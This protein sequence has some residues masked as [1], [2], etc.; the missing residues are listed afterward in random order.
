MPLRLINSID[1]DQNKITVNYSFSGGRKNT[2]TKMNHHY[3]LWGDPQINSAKASFGMNLLRMLI[4]S[5]LLSWRMISMRSRAI[6]FTTEFSLWRR[7]TDF[8][9]K[10]WPWSDQQMIRKRR[11]T[12]TAVLPF[13][14][15][16]INSRLDFSAGLTYISPRGQSL[17]TKLETPLLSIFRNFSVA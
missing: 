16:R 2:I 4:S 10:L 1:E 11:L 13:L 17:R 8:L 5:L 6:R 14:H 7:V 9:S 12:Q 3:E 15:R